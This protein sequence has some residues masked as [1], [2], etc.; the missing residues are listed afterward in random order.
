MGIFLDNG[1]KASLPESIQNTLEVYFEKLGIFLNNGMKA[2]LPKSIQNTL[3]VYF[4]K[5]S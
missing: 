4:E 1:M 3:K 5:L 2:S